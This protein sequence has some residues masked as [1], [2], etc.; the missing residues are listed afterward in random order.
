MVG[1][2]VI[3][4][5]DVNMKSILVFA[6]IIGLCGCADE[7]TESGPLALSPQ[8]TNVDGGIAPSDRSINPNDT[9]MAPT[10]GSSSD[11][12]A[13][14]MEE[15]TSEDSGL[16]PDPNINSEWIGG[17]CQTD[18]DCPYDG[19]YC[20][21]EDQGYPRGMCTQ[22]CSGTCPDLE[23]NPVTFCIASQS[24]GGECHQRCDSA[25]F[26]DSGCRP[27]YR[28][29]EKDRFGEPPANIGT[30]I[31]GE[32]EYRP[33]MMDPMNESCLSALDQLGVQY[34]RAT[35]PD[36]RPAGND[37]LVCALDSPVNLNNTIAGV[38]YVYIVGDVPAPVFVNCEFARALHRFSETLA[39]LDIVR[40][41]HIGTYNCRL[42]GGSN[43]ISEHGFA[44]AIDLQWFETS[45]GR[46]YSVLDHWEHDVASSYWERDISANFATEE[47]RWLYDL[48]RIMFTRGMFNIIL[49]PQF[50]AA[51]DNHFH[52]DL[53]P[54]GR[55]IQNPD[56]PSSVKSN[57]I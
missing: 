7:E 24:S 17:P 57:G 45:D 46:R 49:T 40:V 51:H 3:Y 39:D 19:G 36:D 16:P 33:P 54:G 2:A 37:S 15:Q 32:S 26:G 9:G 25:F 21:T 5:G 10:P 11:N 53:T 50:N 6:L 13:A 55:F 35:S 43:S 47:G 30:C 29:E 14:M 41:G 1:S 22:T 20:L 44:N 34:T 56:I 23:G 38:E 4:Q 31:P 27:G 12:D 52:V 48:G 42:I 28:C 8:S 18:A